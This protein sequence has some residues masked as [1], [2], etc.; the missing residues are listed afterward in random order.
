MKYATTETRVFT[1][2]E[3]VKETILTQ[4]MWIV[5]DFEYRSVI[6]INPYIR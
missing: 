5:L 6:S 1:L 2:A 3:S 4:N